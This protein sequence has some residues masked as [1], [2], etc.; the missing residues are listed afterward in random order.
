MHA[1]N[2]I[3]TLPTKSL[4]FSAT[5]ALAFGVSIQIQTTTWDPYFFA[6]LFLFF[7]VS[8]LF[9]F[10]SFFLLPELVRARRLRR[11]EGGEAA[12]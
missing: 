1:S 10:F 4:L 8:V 7:S 9:F 11:P 12:V 3:T 2:I 5:V 6:F